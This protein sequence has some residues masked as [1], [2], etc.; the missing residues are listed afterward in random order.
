MM[1]RRIYIDAMGK[2]V[3]VGSIFGER[4]EEA[5]FRYDSEY[6]SSEH[7]AAISCSLPLQESPFS[8]AVT[9]A[10]FDG[11]LPEGFTRRSVASQLHVEETD[12][13]AIL[14]AL[15]RECIGAIR[16]VIDDD[17]QEASSYERLTV[18]RL[19]ALAAGDASYSASMMTGSRLSLAGA[20]GKVGLYYDES[21]DAWYQPHGLAPSTHIVKQSHVRL[22][23]IVL[24]EQL[25]MLT[26]GN[27]GIEVPES[28]IVKDGSGGDSVLFATERFDR[29]FPNDAETVNG[30]PK[31][32]RLHQEDFAQAL[33]IP[34]EKKYEVGNDR[35]LQ[36]MTTLLRS[37]SDD[38]IADIKRLFERVII[39]CMIGNADAH[40]KNYSLLYHDGLQHVRLAPAYD[41]LSTVLY[42]ETTR[43]MSFQVGDVYDLRAVD[44]A[45]ICN[46]AK[47]CDV[48]VGVVN[49]IMDRLFDGFV[50]AL[51]KAEEVLVMQGYPEVKQMANT[52]RKERML[53]R[54]V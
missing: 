29:F 43:D 45:T 1:Q 9:R 11:L 20:S 40:L 41:I 53:G 36:R 24:N 25:C 51:S 49:E 8:P 19:H 31:P 2:S 54:N 46:A 10:F 52:I 18:E 50:S 17:T 14:S 4:S 23:Q 34:S 39:H 26:A 37:I 47:E 38:P 16:I 33:G 6:L 21:S 12:Y 27:L 28:F 7:A 48:S 13:L 15:G 44:R 22:S 32:Y 42:S 5:Y 30:L 35:Y 3:H